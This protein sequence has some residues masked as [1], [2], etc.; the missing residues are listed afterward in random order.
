MIV[1]KMPVLCR[2]VLRVKATPFC[3]VAGYPF[4]IDLKWIY[5]LGKGL[6]VLAGS[7]VCYMI[8]GLWRDVRV[9]IPYILIIYIDTTGYL[10]R[11]VS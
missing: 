5:T 11:L 6:L 4:K 3:P 2:S 9:T 8:F 7:P 10:K 1:S